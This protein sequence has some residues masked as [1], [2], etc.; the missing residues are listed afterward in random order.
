MNKPKPK[1]STPKIARPRLGESV[2]VRAPFFAQP[3]VALVISLYEEDT[4][5][6][7]VQAFPVGRDSLQIPA[8]PYFDSEP[9]SDVRSAA[10][11]A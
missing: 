11:A 5:D 6:I 7:A 10:W 1:G 3:T 8:I 2:I 4:T 9:P